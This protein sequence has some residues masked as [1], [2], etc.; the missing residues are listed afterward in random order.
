MIP[1]LKRLLVEVLNQLNKHLFNRYKVVKYRAGFEKESELNY[2]Y[3]KLHG[4][5]K[6]W[7]STKQLEYCETFEH[8]VCVDEKSWYP[9]GQLK[10]HYIYYQGLCVE[11]KYWYES[12]HLYI[13]G[14]IVIRNGI[15]GNYGIQTGISVIFKKKNGELWDDIQYYEN[16]QMRFEMREG[17]ILN[18][19]LND[20]TQG[21][22]DGNGVRIEYDSPPNPKLDIKETIKNGK[23][24]GY[25][26]YKF[27][28]D[29]EIK[30]EGYYK[31]NKKVGIWKEYKDGKLIDLDY[32]QE[33]TISPEEEEWEAF[34]KA[35]REDKE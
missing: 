9:S 32:D 23:R 2:Y 34:K 12:G 3:G 31:N 6:S 24:D 35:I 18:T 30:K 33:G 29:K 16:G 4:F 11:K 19:W 13:K 10:S 15:L 17:L 26:V 5:Q 28:W 22:K 1:Y 8:G 14:T 7:Y 20:G 21:V 25:A 27:A